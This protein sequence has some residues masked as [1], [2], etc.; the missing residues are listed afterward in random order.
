MKLKTIFRR[1]LALALSLL[2]C[3]VCLTPEAAAELRAPNT[4]EGFDSSRRCSIEIDYPYS[5]DAD[6]QPYVRLYQVASVDA[7]LNFRP[8]GGFNNVKDPALAGLAEQLDSAKITGIW[9]DIATNLETAAVGKFAMAGGGP[10]QVNNGKVKF[11]D[12]A[13]GLY[14]V[15]IERY[16]C[17][18]SDGKGGTIT[19]FYTP[20]PY[21]VCLPN[22]VKETDKKWVWSYDIISEPKP[23]QKDAPGDTFDIHVFKVW[24]DQDDRLGLRPESVTV[25]LLK[26]GV[27]YSKATL[28][29]GNGWRYDWKELGKNATWS[30]TELNAP[31]GYRFNITR[32]PTSAGW[33]FE[34][35][36][37][38][39]TPSPP[40]GGKKDPPG[41]DDPSED[42]DI[43]LEDPEVPKSDPPEE[44][45]S[46]DEVEIP[47][48]DV[49]LADL[50]QTGQLWWPVPFL[51]VGGMFFLLIGAVRRRR[52]EYEE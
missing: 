51:A 42:P 50:P 2:L 39:P 29:A 18:V 37:Y 38:I 3:A 36:N 35:E 15:S 7:K 41:G 13:P 48:E 47:D 5:A 44:P 6:A 34:V 8:V 20:T 24:D 40:P 43:P 19:D 28:Y 23:P 22:Y 14:L 49:P 52:D 30:V 31:S 12:L 1:P 21:L 33:T 17:T 27:I 16:Q 26:D 45:P 11:T 4:I 25:A 10:K 32:T 9:P 46:D